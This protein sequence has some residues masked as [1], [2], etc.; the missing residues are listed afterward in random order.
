MAM[1][2]NTVQLHGRILVDFPWAPL[3]LIILVLW[4]FGERSILAE[5]SSH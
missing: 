1:D 4:M 5:E 3:V 2:E